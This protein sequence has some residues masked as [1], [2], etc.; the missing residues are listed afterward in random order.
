[1]IEVVIRDSRLIKGVAMQVHEHLILDNPEIAI[2]NLQAW[3]AR[4]VRK[5]LEERNAE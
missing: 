4:E 2:K 1:M 3:V 5:M